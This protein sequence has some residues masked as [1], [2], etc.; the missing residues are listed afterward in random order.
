MVENNC[1]SDETH[2]TINNSRR[3][4]LKRSVAG[5][6]LPFSFNRF[7]PQNNT[8]SV[9][10]QW[11]Q[12]GI[13]KQEKVPK[14]WYEHL[15]IVRDVQSELKQKYADAPG[16]K[17]VARVRGDDKFGSFRNFNVRITVDSES[18][19]ANIPQ[20]VDGVQITTT[21]QKDGGP[22][23]CGG[24]TGNINPAQGGI[25]C[26]GDSYGT[27]YLGV[28]KESSNADDLVLT[29][30]HLWGECTSIGGDDLYQG[31]DHYGTVEDYDHR[32]DFATVDGDDGTFG[33]EESVGE[34]KDENGD[35]PVDAWYGDSGI[36]SLISKGED[37]R[38]VYQ[39]G[40]TTGLTSGVLTANNVGNTWSSCIDYYDNGV[41]YDIRNAEGDSG[42]P[43]YTHNSD[44]TKAV[45]VCMNSYGYSST[46]NTIS[47]RGYSGT[48]YLGGTG[49][50]FKYL[51][52]EFGIA[53]K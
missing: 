31:G 11:D 19:G 44:G 43:V 47:C 53:P 27:L 2:N 13:H 39:M 34:I 50:S 5:A 49:I 3:K 25:G 29:A 18:V 32:A 24:F 36:D 7:S 14:A 1:G 26:Q 33:D 9:V 6:L 17:E 37:G 22:T 23:A 30:A 12:D 51:N 38:T 35:W 21:E 52:K 8:V 48:E 46:G 41:Q 4:Y 40:T 45:L 16:V 10:T 20:S 28:N 15:Q 42:G